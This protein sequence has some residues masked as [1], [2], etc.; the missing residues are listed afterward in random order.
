MTPMKSLTR[1]C[2]YQCTGSSGADSTVIADTGFSAVGQVRRPWLDAWSRTENTKPVYADQA[3]ISDVHAEKSAAATS[4]RNS[5][6]FR[7]SLTRAGFGGMGRRRTAYL[8][9]AWMALG[10]CATLAGA[11][12]AAQGYFRAGVDMALD[13]DAYFMDLDCGSATPA[14][15][16]G[17]GS[18]PDGEP[19]R[20]AGE[21]GGAMGLDLAAGYAVAPAVR[22]ELSVLYRPRIPFEGRANFLAPER[23]QSVTVEGASL[24]ALVGVEIELARLGMP[25]PGGFR[26]FAGAGLGRVRHRLDEMRMRFPRT[27]T[28]VPGAS[29]WERTWSLTAGL[30]RPLGERTLV[31]LAWRY[32]HE[33]GVE[34]G[35]GAGRVEWRDGSRV[36]PLDLA[37]TRA[38]ARRHGIRLSV[39]HAR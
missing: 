9:L 16:Y 38:D 34:T 12:A 26:P 13:A 15:L 5:P 27:Q 24:A 36:L 30:A 10:A 8:I 6:I 33:G 29:G 11:Q 32:T 3:E 20:S 23:E 25:S 31:E 22:V 4:R 37:P 19:R 1:S 35:Q 7:V 18:G 2:Q 28:F 17:C 39:R 14:A 21:F